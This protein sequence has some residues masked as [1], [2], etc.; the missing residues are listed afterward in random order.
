MEI[1]RSITSRLSAV[2]AFM[3]LA[4]TAGCMAGIK[5]EFKPSSFTEGQKFSSR[6]K[7]AEV[8]K[9]TE[10][11]MMLEGYVLL[12]DIVAWQEGDTSASQNVTEHA[13]AEAGSRGGDLAFLISD[14]VHRMETRY[15]NGAC[16][17]SQQQQTLV[18]VPHYETVC[19]SSTGA[20]HSRQT[21]S[22]TETRYQTICVRYQQI[23]Y[24]VDL[25]ETIARVFRNE[26]D[27]LRK[28]SGQVLIAAVMAE[29]PDK[30][31]E[32]VRK[33]AQVD[34]V[35]KNGETALSEAAARGYGE[36]VKLLL[37]RGSDINLQ[38]KGGET[39]LS[40][41]AGGG[42]LETVKL[43]I[44]KGAD[45][46]GDLGQSALMAALMENQSK[47]ANYL[48]ERH[49]C[50]G[51][52]DGSKVLLNAARS[53]NSEIVELVLKCG[54]NI[55]GKHAGGYTPLMAAVERGHLGITKFLLDRGAKV[56]A[57]NRDNGYTPLFYAVGNGHVQIVKLLISGGA[58]V[59]ARIG[60]YG[61]SV[62]EMAGG[63][64]ELIRLLKESDAK[65]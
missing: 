57:K 9:K 45:V 52:D 32:F 19:D 23:P 43:L 36:L 26:P 46:K 11:E 7:P 40:M 38:G 25:T 59:S 1:V 30:A 21:Y 60:Q 14:H 42:R 24:T 17:E 53:G 12:G 22:T 8:T 15:R 16:L 35:G 64:K 33:G 5:A 50:I 47:V 10:S 48:V 13:L 63:N 62:L 34:A 49:V 31:L 56:N 58:D 4:V 29:Q 65:H 2:C 44:D 37:T 61:K 41:A 6:G 54:A 27:L 55:E 20:C 28:I 39:P 3:I 51:E 18:S